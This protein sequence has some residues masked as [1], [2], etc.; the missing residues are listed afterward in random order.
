M[1]ITRSLIWTHQIPPERYTYKIYAYF[2]DF[3]K[4]ISVFAI[5]T[6]S[7]IVQLIARSL[8]NLQTLRTNRRYIR[9]FRFSGFGT[10]TAE[11]GTAADALRHV[12]VACECSA[13][14]F[15]ARN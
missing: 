12:F 4:I 2:L 14:A 8:K 11:C 6:L 5:N 10:Q 3:L 1:V 9:D 15:P 13:F 7:F